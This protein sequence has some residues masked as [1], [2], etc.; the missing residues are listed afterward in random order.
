MQTDNTYNTVSTT[1]PDVFVWTH[2]LQ[3][4]LVLWRYLNWGVILEVIVECPL[5]RYMT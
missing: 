2:F 3:G 1:L 4:L 5:I